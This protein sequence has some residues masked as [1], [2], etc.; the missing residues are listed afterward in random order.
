MKKLVTFV[1]LTFSISASSQHLISN[2]T[3]QSNVSFTNSNLPIVLLNTNGVT[4][5]DEPKIDATMKIIY[6]GAGLINNVTDIPNIY[7]GNIGIELRGSSS[8]N[9]PQKPYKLETRNALN[10]KQNVSLL[11]MPSESDWILLSN[12]ND[13]VFMR[14]TLA[15]KIFNEMGNY[16]TKNR[17]CEVVLN[18]E[19]VGIYLL[20]ENIKRGNDRVNIAKLDL[21]DNDGIELTGGYIIK[22]DYWEETNSWLSNYH[23]I[24]HPNFDVYMVYEY[25]KAAVITTQQKTY[26]QGFVNDFETVLYST[27]Y[28]DPLNGYNKYIDVNTF[29]DYL[30]V[31]ELA[32]NG[33]GFKKSSYFNKNIDMPTAISKMKAGPVWDFDW[34]WKNINECAIF[35][36]TNGAGWAHLVNNC[37]SDVNSPGW[38]VRLLQDVNFQNKLRCRW[39][40]L[41][42]NILSETSL[43]NYIDEN[44]LN[45][46][47]A[48]SRHYQKW[49]HLGLNTGTPEV[50][51]I[52]TTFDAHIQSFKDWISVRLIWLDAN[53]PGNAANCSLDVPKIESFGSNITIFPNPAKSYL[54][55]SNIEN[56]AVN[57]MEII[58]VSGKTIKFFKKL[59][60][61]NT[62]FDITD[63]ENGIYFCRLSDFNNNYKTFKL[64][65]LH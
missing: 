15:Y 14:N 63:V 21:I 28:A 38:F 42:Q 7:D 6:N 57:S 31:N 60:T 47:Q 2:T 46:N 50:G 25:P 58:D 39:N 53:I 48:Q 41:R 22:N 55:I 3:R 26:I 61:E 17:F 9:Y 49:E 43:N 5:P 59:F 51:T 34:A 29:I 4:I 10:V 11:G 8:I 23:P 12:Y 33:D 36:Q 16:S 32:R 35:A 65:I 56:N 30:I 1:I 24:D 54:S 40:V 37:N 52:P 13:K 44:A 18:G 64:V 45:L 27:N 62:N 19:Y 20:M